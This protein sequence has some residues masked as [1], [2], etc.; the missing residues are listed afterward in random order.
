MKSLL[1]EK[2]LKFDESEKSALKGFATQHRI[3]P[4][5]NITFDPKTFLTIVKQ[6][7]MEKF[8]TRTKVRL[9]LIA[10]MEQITKSVIEIK[11]FQSKSKI[12]LKATNLN[13]LWN[14][15]MEQI[16]ENISIFQMKGSG[17][18]FHSIVNFE[19]HTVGYKPLR[20]GIHV[21]LPKFQA[22]KKA[23]IDMK[24]KS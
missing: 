20:G 16:L 13:E 21:P 9:V 18:T 11:N 14:E 4:P 22:S 23:L 7:A 12:I 6:K 19:I 1:D 24:F 17:W 5:Q 15:V 8:K 10:R 2:Q 3:K